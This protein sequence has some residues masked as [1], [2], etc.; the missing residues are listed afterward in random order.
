MGVEPQPV[1][2]VYAPDLVADAILAAAERPSVTHRRRQRPDAQ[3]V[4]ARPAGN[5]RLHGA[6]AVRVPKTDKPVFGRADNLFGPVAHEAASAATT[7]GPNNSPQRFDAAPPS[8]DRQCNDAQ[9]PPWRS[10]SRRMSGVARLGRSGRA[11]KGGLKPQKSA[12]KRFRAGGGGQLD[13]NRSGCDRNGPELLR[14][15]APP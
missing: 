15:V 11:K 14:L 12:L 9:L 10:R 1:P 2:P 5:G 4:V 6:E 7:A 13:E 8:E 3:Y